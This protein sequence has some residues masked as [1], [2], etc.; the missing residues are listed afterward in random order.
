MKEPNILVDALWASVVAVLLTAMI[1]VGSI[2]GQTK[3]PIGGQDG[4]PGVVTFPPPVKCEQVTC[5][6]DAEDLRFVAVRV[7]D[8]R[9]CEFSFESIRREG[10]MQLGQDFAIGERSGPD[11]YVKVRRA[12]R[13]GDVGTILY[14]SACNTALGADL[15]KR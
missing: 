5:T 13:R 12:L 4:R 3:P 1:L 11:V 7:T 8:V 10:I 6:H 2:F 14:C 15:L 9:T